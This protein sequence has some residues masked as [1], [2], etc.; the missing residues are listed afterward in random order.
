MDLDRLD[1]ELREHFTPERRAAVQAAAREAYDR[2][3]LRYSPDDGDD[4]QLLG[5]TIYKFIGKR[6][7]GLTRRADLGLELHSANPMIRIGVGP[8]TLAAYCCGSTADQPIDESFPLNEHGAPQLVDL[9][10]FCLDIRDA[11]PIPRAVVLAHLGNPH[12]GLEA[13]YLAV[14]SEKEENRISSWCYTH[15]LWRRDA[16]DEHGGGPPHPDLPRP[17]AIPPAPLS[18]K[19]PAERPNTSDR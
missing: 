18:L 7:V 14:P 17:V 2:A 5:F 11:Q 10:Q 9:N 6:L 15:L 13:L 16:D 8:F 12:T 3:A 1:A 19:Q 4:S